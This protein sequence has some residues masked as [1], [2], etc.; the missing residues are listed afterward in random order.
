MKATATCQ[1]CTRQQV[2][3]MAHNLYVYDPTYNN[4]TTSSLAS[5]VSAGSLEEF[6]NSSA[7][8]KRFTNKCWTVP[9]SLKVE[10][11]KLVREN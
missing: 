2:A 11:I 3:L 10:K 7:F 8:S 1:W 6:T 4:K 9:I 5:S